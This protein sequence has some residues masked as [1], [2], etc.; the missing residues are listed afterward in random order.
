MNIKIHGD[1]VKI[2]PA[3]KS[4]IEE[5]ISKLNKYFESPEEIEAKVLVRIKNND[6]I[7]EVTVPTQKFTLRAEESHSDLYAATDLVIDKL[8]N[9]FRKNKKRLNDKLKK[10]VKITDFIFDF[11]DADVQNKNKI[12]KRK[13]IESKP[14]DE[15]E[16]ILQMEL[17][18][19][20]FFIFNN[21]EEDCFSVVYKRK[22]GQY[23]IINTN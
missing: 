17:L 7:I 2:T 22:D 14:M 20:D 10:D 6:Q 16:A 15:E 9:Q 4:Y 18:N 1:K 19:H 5:K 12:V 11:D 13:N 8:D 21:V 3:I 23:G